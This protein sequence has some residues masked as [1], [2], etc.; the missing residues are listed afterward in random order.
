[1]E[2]TRPRVSWHRLE[3]LCHQAFSLVPKLLLGNP[4][5]RN[6]PLCEIIRWVS[7]ILLTPLEVPKQSLGQIYV[8]KRE[9]G[10]EK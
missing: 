2:D 10:N 5:W 7:I 4:L 3:S 9:L 1:M 8:P 6:A